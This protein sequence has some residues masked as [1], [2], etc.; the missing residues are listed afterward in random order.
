MIS[1]FTK[2][3][4]VEPPPYGVIYN[5]C[6]KIIFENIYIFAMRE[7]KALPYRGLEIFVHRDI[8]CKFLW[9]SNLK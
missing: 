7:H 3:V 4:G 9:Q 6:T 8:I 5:L 2:S 1:I